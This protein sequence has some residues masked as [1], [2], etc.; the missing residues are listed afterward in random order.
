MDTHLLIRQALETDKEAIWEIIRQVIRN[1]DTYVF[2]P[3]TPKDEMLQYWFSN[4]TYTFVAEL[5]NKIAGTF[6]FKANQPGLGSHVANAAFM[7]NPAMQG[8][9]IGSALGEAA[10]RE[11][12]QAGFLAMQFNIVV[13]TN[14]VAK[15]LWDK[16]GF[17]T[18]GRLPK[19]FNHAEYGLTDA[20]VM[21]RFL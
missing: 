3:D 7:V 20:F 11:A 10:L 4:G 6:I 8:K 18:I 14:T 1:G 9:G 21:H 15:R 19:V 16:L 13:S 2:S 12:K 5:E 17:T